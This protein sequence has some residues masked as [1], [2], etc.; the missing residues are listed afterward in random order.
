MFTY[1]KEKQEKQK[2]VW[3]SNLR[4]LIIFANNFPKKCSFIQVI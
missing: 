3:D 2:K 4:L 1:P